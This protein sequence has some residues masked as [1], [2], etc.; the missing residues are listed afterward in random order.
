V[1]VA[2]SG[3]DK[4]MTSPDGITWT[5]QSTYDAYNW[6]DVVYADGKLVA[7][8]YTSTTTGGVMTG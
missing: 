3:Y 7:V 8:G 1:A 6:F 4:V 5:S 2:S